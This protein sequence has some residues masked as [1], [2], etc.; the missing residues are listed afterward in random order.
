VRERN[1]KLQWVCCRLYPFICWIIIKSN[2]RARR[3]I[4]NSVFHSSNRVSMRK[5][6]V[7]HERVNFKTQLT[8]EGP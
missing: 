5:L 7:K 2:E 4:S 6:Q 8:F 1:M 3:Y